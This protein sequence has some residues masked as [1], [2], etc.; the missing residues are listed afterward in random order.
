MSDVAADVGGLD[1]FAFEIERVEKPWGHEIV[2]AHT[3]NFAG[4]VIH[5]RK[6]EQL[7]LQFHREKEEVVYVHEGQIEL[8]VRERGR[9]PTLEVVGAG[10][11]FRLAPGVVHRWKA[12]EDAVILEAS[13]PQLDDVVRLE[14]RYGRADVT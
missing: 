7:S 1:R 13:T 9:P 6:G 10:R 5:V 11:A 2:F 4:K 8:E 14:D 12:L 3:E